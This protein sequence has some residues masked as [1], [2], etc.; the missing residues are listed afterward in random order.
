MSVCHDRGLA[1]GVCDLARV[2]VDRRRLLADRELDAACGRRSCRGRPGSSPLAVLARGEPAEGLPPGRPA[3][4]PRARRRRRRRARR[5]RAGAGSGGWRPARST[6]AGGLSR[7]YVVSVG[8]AATSPTA[9][10]L[11][12]DPRRGGARELRGERLRS[13]RGGASA[14]AL[15]LSSWTL[16]RRTATF[17]ATTP[18]SRTAMTDDPDHAAREPAPALGT[19]RLLAPAGLGLGLPCGRGEA[20]RGGGVALRR[21]GR[22]RPRSSPLPAAAPTPR[23][24]SARSPAASA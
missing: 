17:S 5:L 9:M 13:P 22:L 24:G 18:A 12:L 14:R 4:R 3:A 11:L 15:S 19:R 7:T 1:A 10:R 23:A 20:K 21:P 16:S 2:G 6:R 8:S